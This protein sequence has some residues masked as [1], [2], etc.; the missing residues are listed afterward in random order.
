MNPKSA[1]LQPLDLAIIN[2]AAWKLGLG[3]RLVSTVI[4]D[5]EVLSKR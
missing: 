5:L 2:R 3:Q 4:T 1:I